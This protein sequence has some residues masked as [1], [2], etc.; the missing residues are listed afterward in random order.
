M[1]SVAEI[2][3][4]NHNFL[5]ALSDQRTA[6]TAADLGSNFIKLRLR[7]E[8]FMRKFI[9]PQDVTDSEIQIVEWTDLPRIV[10]N[11]ETDAPAAIS[12]GYGATPIDVWIK[13]RRWVCT[14]TSLMSPRVNVL[15]QQLRTYNFDVRKVWADNIVKD[16]K[17]E[18][19]NQGITTINALLLG[20]DVNM[21]DT[22]VP[23]WRTI[24][25]GISRS[26]IVEGGKI[27]LQTP[28]SI[29]PESALTTAVTLMD[30]MKW[31]RD[32]AGGD[33]A[34][35]SIKDGW[36]RTKFAGLEW[37]GTIKR[38]LIPDGSVYYFAPPK[39]FGVSKLFSPMQMFVEQKFSRYAF[40]I[41]YE[42]GT[43]IVNTAAVG[44][45]DYT[46]ST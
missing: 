38:Y 42:I 4:S 22:G 25:G 19:D 10:G 33:L 21:Y 23:Q 34:E 14:G 32:E 11:M 13:P 6:K 12:V 24:S 43:T 3:E 5:A 26:S 45:A 30:F 37:Y 1:A 2:K 16:T 31:G 40:H 44:R 27:L 35:Q 46:L 7:E 15:R 20:A 9:P 17:Y 39:W 29:P 36:T 28:N 18:E 41:E 8:G